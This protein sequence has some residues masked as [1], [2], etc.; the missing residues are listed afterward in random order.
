MHVCNPRTWLADQKL[1]VILNYTVIF[2]AS[3]GYMRLCP[4][5]RER[6]R[7]RESEG[8]RNMEEQRW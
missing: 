2:K 4:H 6:E 5:Q 3:L 1:K 7:Q 8:E